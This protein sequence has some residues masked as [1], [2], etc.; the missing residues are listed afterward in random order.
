MI[1]DRWYPI[2]ESAR[3]ARRPVGAKRLGRKW[4]L[5]RDADG[6]A[7]AMPS[8][9]PHRGAALERGRVIDGQLACPWHGFRFDAQGAC[10]LAPCEGADARI[11]TALHTRVSVLREAHGLVWMWLGQE[12]A[13]YPELPWFEEVT[14]DPRETAQASYVLPYH[15]SRMMET[16]LDIHH[17][18][19]VHGSVIP[20][21]G[22]RVDPYEAHIEGDR[23]LSSGELRKESKTSGMA[24][25]IDALLPC[26]ALVELTPKLR[27]VASATPVDEQHTWMWFRYYQDYARFRPIGALISWLAVQSELRIV[28]RQDWR[29]FGGLAGGTIDDVPFHF[30]RADQGIALYRRRRRELLDEA[31]PVREAV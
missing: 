16:N 22:A 13:T 28:Q 29:L 1:P 26:L 10:R 12:R 25:R 21:L 7:V 5:W 2:L 6:R 11:P 14:Q 18:P 23:I 17:T 24:F 4:V 3:L 9:C 20:G 8:A 19:F 31:A 27:L 30:V 15:Y